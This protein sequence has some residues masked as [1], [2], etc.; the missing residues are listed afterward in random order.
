M[1]AAGLRK[2]GVLIRDEHGLGVTGFDKGKPIYVDFNNKQITYRRKSSQSE[3]IARAIGIKK[4]KSPV[5]VD[6][7]AGL[8]RDSFMLA[9]MGCQVHMIERSEIIA[10]LLTDGITRGSNDQ[11]IA[12]IIA[13]MHLHIGDAIKLLKRFS[14]DVVYLDPM[15]SGKTNSALVKKEMRIFREIV[16]D[17]EDAAELLQV[18]LQSAKYRV[19]VKRPRKSSAFAGINPTYKLEGNACRFDVYQITPLTPN[20]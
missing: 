4:I 12:H 1:K 3:L 9:A 7:T 8:G 14:P 16:G 19:V 18:A 10:A 2:P 20:P 11:E 17:D 13:R 6:A 5:I 15:F